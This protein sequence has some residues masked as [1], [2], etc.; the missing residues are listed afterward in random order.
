MTRRQSSPQKQPRTDEWKLKYEQLY[1][2]SVRYKE[3]INYLNFQVLDLK[4][5]SNTSPTKE[6]TFIV[7]DEDDAKW[8][9]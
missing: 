1:E 7:D 3:Q 4:K 6:P 2:E 9:R 5:K 8:K